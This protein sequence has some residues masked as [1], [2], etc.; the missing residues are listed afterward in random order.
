MK[1]AHLTAAVVLLLA[2][3]ACGA[4]AHQ[5]TVTVEPN[6]ATFDVPFTIRAT[7]FPAR[8]S[9]EVTFSGATVAGT[10]LRGQLT[11]STDEHGELLLPNEFLYA[12]MR[13]STSVIIWPEHVTVTVEAGKRKAV[14]AATRA[15]VAPSSIASSHERPDKVGFFGEWVRPIHAHSRTAILLFGGAEGGLYY[16]SLVS[17]LAGHGYPVLQLAYFSEPGLRQSLKR[18]RLEYFLRALRWLAN[19]PEVDPK[20]IVTWGWS[21]GG[22][23]SLVL[24]AT[25]PT[26]VR[27]AVAY[28][29]SA[30][31]LPSPVDRRSPAWT[32]RGKPLPTCS[33][34]PT[35]ACAIPIWRSAGPIFAVGGGDDKIW[36]SGLF[37]H[38]IAKAMTEHGRTDFT[39]LTYPSAGHLLAQ[40]VPPQLPVGS[41]G[42]GLIQTRYGPLDAGGSPLADELGLERSWPKLLRFLAGVRR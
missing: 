11:A 38:E 10:T 40:A 17:T 27:A 42:Y 6:R 21:R 7:G 39:A 3:S 33:G 14:G 41:I 5:A 18:I 12:R 24:A 36:P 28:V 35:T 13:A 9:A 25:F 32:Y 31:V 34:I 16:D 2:G 30:Y 26:I 22:E 37:V 19:R 23:A 29:P 20:R 4:R 8:H 1:R 15:P